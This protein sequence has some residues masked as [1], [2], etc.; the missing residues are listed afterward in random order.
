[1][2]RGPRSIP[3][4]SLGF[5]IVELLTVLAIIGVLVAIAMPAVQRAR[6]AARRTTC[7]NHLRKIAL[8]LANYES[9]FERY[10]VGI[11][12]FDAPEK[13]SISWL[14]FILP[15]IEQANVWDQS[16]ESFAADPNPFAHFGL[17]TLISMYACP[18]DPRSGEI[19]WTHENKIVASTNYVGVNGTDY[20]ALDGILFNESQIRAIDVVDGLSHTLIVGERPPSS[21]YW[22]GWWYS[23]YGQ[24]G[25]GSVDMLLGVRE[26]NEH[27]AY[28]VGGCPIGPH[29]FT[30]GRED[31]PC[32]ALHYWS[33]HPGGAYFAFAGGETRFLPY[34]ANPMLPL[35]AT[36]AGREPIGP[37]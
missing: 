17:R 1:M 16:L 28:D 26:I 14:A 33:H 18:S 30:S 5:T 34:D 24:L 12:A 25:T 31:E 3:C 27:T 9:T 15:Q 10:P 19:H 35:L 4:F 20:R 37:F 22:Y 21:D 8:G 6:E 13:P 2:R 32:D 23:G 11:K 7:G 36:R 29:F